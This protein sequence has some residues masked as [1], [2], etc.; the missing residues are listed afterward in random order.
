MSF[1]Y[2]IVKEIK[3]WFIESIGIKFSAIFEQYNLEIYSNE[4]IHNRVKPLKSKHPYIIVVLVLV[5][6]MLGRINM[7]LTIPKYSFVVIFKID[8]FISLLWVLFTFKLT[9]VI[10]LPDIQNPVRKLFMLCSTIWIW[11]FFPVR[12][13]YLPPT[14]NTTDKTVNDL[15]HNVIQSFPVK[16]S[17][18]GEENLQNLIFNSISHIFALYEGK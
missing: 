2:S 10:R 8:I 15:S 5:K 7:L 17:A 9:L 6:I 14:R 13:R 16:R 1:C 12:W 4:A 18:G 11:I 3:L